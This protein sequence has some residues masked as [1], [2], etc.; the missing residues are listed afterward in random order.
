MIRVLLAEDM[1]MV[2][3]ALVALLGLEPDIRVVSQVE[4]GDDILT[5]AA[6]HRPDVAIIDVDLPG[7]DG[8][9][10]A[11]ELRARLPDCRILIL[12]SLDQPGALRR[13][14]AAQVGGYLLKD[15][16]P[17]ELAAAIRKVATGHLVVAPQLAVSAWQNEREQP[18]TPRELT[19]LRLAAEGS[20]ITQIAKQLHLSAGTVRN[21]LTSI[22]T[23]LNARNRLDAVRIARTAGWL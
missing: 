16:P 2:R 1:H 11:G 12:T 4:R 3:G 8:I 7:T 18:L 6:K 23:K 10:A 15:A 14:M 22:V 13:A 5:E 19:V 20:E 21:Y 9:T 17:H